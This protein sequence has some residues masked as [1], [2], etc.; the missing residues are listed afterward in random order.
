MKHL[1]YSGE[2]VSI[3]GV[4][5]RIDIMQEAD[6]PFATVG[7]LEFPANEPLVIEYGRKDKENVICGSTATLR[8]ISPGDRTYE[9]LYTIETGRIRMDVYRDQSLYWSGIID[10]EF[11][12][13]PYEKFDEYEVVLTFSDFGIL[14]R[15]TYG[16]S[17][18]H[19]LL[20][21]VRHIIDCS[22][23]LYRKIDTSLISTQC[24]DGRSSI[25]GLSVRS[26]NFIDE[27]G[28]ASTLDEVLE[29]ILQPLAL[30]IVQRY[31]DIFL[32]DLNGLYQNGIGKTIA[33]YGDSQTM[34]TDKVANNI[35]V[36]FSPYSSAEMCSGD[37]VYGGRYDVGHVYLGGIDQNDPE[38]GNYFSYLPDYSMYSNKPDVDIDNNLIDFTIFTHGKGSGVK[39]I[40]DGCQYCHILPV[41]G[42]TTETTGIA[43]AY[44]IG[45]A[46]LETGIPQWK[47]H[48]GV[49][50]ASLNGNS[51]ILTTNRVFLPELDKINS[52][53]YKIRIA[54]EILI[55]A[56]YNPFSG[57]TN[58][59]EE[60]ND[61][62]LKICSAF[63]FIPVRITLY[64]DAG[65]ALYHYCNRD[66]AR[67]GFNGDLAY[68]T[69]KWIEGADPGGDCWLEYYNPDDLVEDAGIRGWKA[70]RHCIGRPDGKGGRSKLKLIES[71]K[72]LDDGE[73]LPYPPVSGYLE[74]Q[75][76][77]GIL[78]YDYGRPVD[79]CGFGSYESQWDKTK[80][81][82]MLRWC[83]YK[84]PVVE[85]V[86]NNLI[87]DVAELDDVEY[88]GYINKN[89]RE[90]I[91]I[92]TICG[93]AS[94][95]SP[96]A[97]G[98]Y[99]HT[100][101][102]TQISKLRRANIE[103]HPEKLL[104]GTLYSQYAN[105]KTT[106]TG[107]ATIDGELHYYTDH[108][109][110]GKRFMLMSDVQNAIMDCTNAEY[111]EFRPDEYDSIE[112]MQ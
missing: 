8:I 95:I 48:R 22:G 30:R 26:E 7:S 69:G 49:P 33:W 97:R 17:G 21:I 56:R 85:V 54:E 103:D 4:G 82:D 20:S 32:Y 2:F 81:Y 112:E 98:I 43:Y 75:I 70:N 36:S 58:K 57:S 41:L 104:I 34:G 47:I 80:I 9:D 92:N 88:S 71:F 72:K 87:F 110:E 38:Y 61:K 63:V 108:N 78:G 73:Y 27:D 29:G 42:S 23:I 55:D 24:L 44:R 109:Q 5:W 105:R 1:R 66:I 79:D 68:C 39:S 46:S 62:M 67:A 107:D 86:N 53:K 100:Y 25:G 96:M 40:G 74:V 19:S 37:L 106:L 99:Y 14:S 35:V 6:K 13:E 3:S 10:P 64:D 50:H 77:S 11:Y 83:L 15:L 102:E 89:A 111:C 52:Q 12:E 28:V 60:S 16:L 91:N 93:T 18:M 94:V 90:G 65:K 76:Q 31:G 84:A 45:F 101:S 51:E 59:N